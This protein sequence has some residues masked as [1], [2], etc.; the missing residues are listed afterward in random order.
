MLH[1]AKSIAL[2]E[3]M[4]S[5][6]GLMAL[7]MDAK[8]AGHAALRS[9]GHTT[10]GT[11]DYSQPSANVYNNRQCRNML[12]TK[13]VQQIN[14]VTGSDGV[15]KYRVPIL[16]LTKIPGLSRNTKTFFQFSFVAQQCL[17]I[18]TNSSYL[19]Y[20]HT[21]N[22]TIHRRTFITSCKKVFH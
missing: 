19:L 21:C 2:I 1:Q 12:T 10:V 20:V 15:C 11:L 22:S 9:R 3:Q 18:Q 16:L 13:R 5:C 17:K 7:H 6:C 14:E 8:H 4:S